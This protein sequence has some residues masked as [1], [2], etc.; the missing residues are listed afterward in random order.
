[1]H[2]QV[3]KATLVYGKRG[4]HTLA[5]LRYAQVSKE[6]YHIAKET[7]YT[8]KRDLPILACLRYANVNRPLLPYK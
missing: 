2:A 3:S 1:M 6:A 7:Y 8:H 5:Y 4:L